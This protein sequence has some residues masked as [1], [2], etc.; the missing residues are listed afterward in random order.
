MSKKK[1]RSGHKY[2]GLLGELLSIAGNVYSSGPITLEFSLADCDNEVARE[3][4]NKHFVY[5]LSRYLNFC[6]YAKQLVSIYFG[7]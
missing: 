2:I 4:L 3:L 7:V 6:Y 1:K 5:T